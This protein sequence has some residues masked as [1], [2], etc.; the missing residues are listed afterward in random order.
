MSWTGDQILVG[1]GD[2]AAAPAGGE[3]RPAQILAVPAN[4]GPASALLT[5]AADELVQS[6]Q[7]VNGGKAVLFTLRKGDG[8]WQD[9]SVVVQDLATGKRTVLVDRGTDARV[10]GAGYLIYERESTLFAMAFDERRLAVTG[11]PVPVQ[12]GV[13]EALGNF[14]GAAQAAISNS[15]SL[16]FVPTSGIGATSRALMWLDRK[17]TTERLKL[18]PALHFMG[19]SQTLSPDGTRVA[20]RVI[21]GSSSALADIWIGHL[22]NGIF[23]RITFAGR[24]T[25]PVW[26]PDGLRVCYEN[27]DEVLCQPADGSGAARTLFKWPRMSTID[28]LSPD[29][30]WLLFSA[31]PDTTANNDT[32]VMDMQS[33]SD[34]RPLIRDRAR[35]RVPSV[36]RDG[37]W[38]AY[39]SG[40]SARE[41]VYVRPF[42][43]VDGGRWQVSTD[44]GDR[45]TWSHDGRE[46]FYLASASA[47][48]TSDVTIMRV[49]IKAG[50]TFSA[51]APE[52]VVKLPPNAAF[53]F[54][55]AADGRFLINVPAS[56]DGAGRNRMVLVQHWIEELKAKVP[57]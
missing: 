14:S 19:R 52:A 3:R 33:P 25:D 34:I 46:L 56:D 39:T 24:V 30:R 29:G 20:S 15:G 21:S 11:S 18:P 44:G 6:P 49:P 38:I 31:Q 16:V 42:P 57:R 43:A 47:G 13:Q 54:S 2:P 53:N 41:D 28:T 4:G 9:A 51:G 7:L 48:G 37:R 23:T 10:L 35:S 45:P 26:S 5:G 12:T 22:A 27:L 50:P 8:D 32:F 36:S 40:E 17:G 1:A 55:V